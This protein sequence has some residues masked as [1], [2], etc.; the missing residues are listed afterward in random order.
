[1][2]LTWCTQVGLSGQYQDN[3]VSKTSGTSGT[4]NAGAQSAQRIT[5]TAV[6]VGTTIVETNLDR[7]IGLQAYASAGVVTYTTMV[8]SVRFKADGNYEV[9]EGSSSV[10][11]PAA[12]AAADVFEIKIESNVFKVYKN[13]VLVYT[14][15]LTPTYP[16]RASCAFSTTNATISAGTITGAGVTDEA[17]TYDVPEQFEFT[18]PCVPASYFG[19]R[20]P[21]PIGHSTGQGYPRSG[22]SQY[23]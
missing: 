7:A 11:G 5:A 23:L 22:R 21:Q 10:F 17:S 4:F 1:M 18:I 13:T 12:Y 8:I 6:V 19:G 20:T 14:S 16:L 9:Y 2:D 15:G 3:L